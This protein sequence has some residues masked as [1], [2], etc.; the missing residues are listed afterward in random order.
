MLLPTTPPW[1]LDTENHQCGP[2]EQP[3]SA[4]LFQSLSELPPVVEAQ[5]TEL[6]HFLL[7][8]L[9]ANSIPLPLDLKDRSSS[10]YQVLGRAATAPRWATTA[11][12]RSRE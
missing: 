6:S 2:I 1:Y 8:Q 9:P 11:F 5:L 7:Q 4:S 3:V 10:R 12:E